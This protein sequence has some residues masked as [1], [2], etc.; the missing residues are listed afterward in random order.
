MR[1]GKK[2]FGS[3]MQAELLP[4]GVPTLDDASCSAPQGFTPCHL[5]FEAGQFGM[6]NLPLVSD[7]VQRHQP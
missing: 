4:I 3:S 7:L 5:E 1:P 6:H 2:N